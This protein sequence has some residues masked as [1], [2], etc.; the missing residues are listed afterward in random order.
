MATIDLALAGELTAP[1]PAEE[2]PAL[3]V[4]P[5]V[6]APAPLTSDKPTL[7]AD[8]KRAFDAT[9]QASLDRQK[10]LEQAMAK[11]QEEENAFDASA[12]TTVNTA[13]NIVHGANVRLGSIP[14]PGGITLPLVILLVFFFLLIPV[15]G[16]TRLTWLWL[17]LSGNAAINPTG[18]GAESSGAAS[19]G[20]G[21]TAGATGPGPVTIPNNP[22]APVPIPVPIT[23]T[24]PPMNFFSLPSFT[25]VEEL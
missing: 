12:R 5:G 9:R 10:L 25:G 23:A 17:A 2:T 16:H 15:N 22:A 24:Q 7:T 21:D 1:K 20:A 3:D 4:V 14:T 11:R 13:K 19:P 6:E 8:E 18:A